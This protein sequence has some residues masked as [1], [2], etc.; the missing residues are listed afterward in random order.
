MVPTSHEVSFFVPSCVLNS[1][2]TRLKSVICFS[3]TA[4]PSRC[5]YGRGL[6]FLDFAGFFVAEFEIEIERH[7]QD[8]ITVQSEIADSMNN[9]GNGVSPGYHGGVSPGYHGG[10][11]VTLPN[12]GKDP[13]LSVDQPG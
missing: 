10:V 8:G 3:S 5:R 11:F 6:Y 7:E 12:P 13:L 2:D 9:T 4:I 1:A